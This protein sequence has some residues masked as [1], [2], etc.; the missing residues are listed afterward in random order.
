MKLRLP[1]L[2]LVLVPGLLGLLSAG[3]FG[4]DATEY[5]WGVA[6]YMSYDNNLERCGKP[7]LKGIKKGCTSAKQIVAVQ[8]DFTNSEGMTRYTIKSS[9]TEETKID[10]EDSAKE[11]TAATYLDWFVKNFKCKKYVFTF[12]DHGGKI[13]QMCNDDNPGPSGKKWMSGK[14]MG[15]KLRAMK[16]KLGDKLQLLFLQQC[17]RGSLENLYNFRGVG[18]YIMASPIPVGAPNTY[19]EAIHKW[20]PEHPNATGAEIADKIADEDDH[21][22][23]YTCLKTSKL[24][25]LPKRLDAMLK[26]F[27]EME[28]IKRGKKLRVIHPAGEPIV[29]AKAYFEGV[30]NAN[31]SSR[32]LAEVTTFFEWTK[33]ELFTYVRAKDEDNVRATSL[34]GLSVY[35]ASTPKEAKRYEYLDL[36][37]QTQLPAFWK[38]AATLEDPKDSKGTTKEPRED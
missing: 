30:A 25:E 14:V 34:C 7:I 21:W 19:Y 35:A 18:E 16:E 5:D 36:Y 24:D 27:L 4:E 29:D 2:G 15:E 9:G 8:A 3:S 38:K 12:L 33:K 26:P 32:A 17:G 37:K 13:D 28:T 11:D 31:S 10:T 1:L 22:T 23:N 20:L 6:Y